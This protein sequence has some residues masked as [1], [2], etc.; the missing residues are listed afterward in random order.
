MVPVVF[1]QNYTAPDKTELLFFYG[2]GCPHCSQMKP[3][4]EELGKTY[5]DLDVKMYEV[6]S[7]NEN[8]KLMIDLA[9]AY[10]KEVSGVP[11]VFLG[12]NMIVGYNDA[13]G[14]TVEQEVKSCIQNGCD[15]P[16]DR[17]ERVN[18]QDATTIEGDS[19]PHEDPDRSAQIKTLTIPAVIGAAVVDAINP[20]AFAVLI[21]LLTT[22]LAAG[23]R[24]RVIYA[25]L[26]F[27]TSV[28]I[29]YFLMGIG[30][31]SALQAAGLTGTFYLIIS[32]LAIVVGL[33][34]LKDYL[35]YGKWFTM[36]VPR[37][38][39][40]KMKILLKSVTSIPGAFLVGFV[41]S[42]FLLPC[43]S[44][45]YIVILGLLAQVAS[46][47]YAIQML[48]LYNFIFVLPMILIT[49]AI[50]FG[51]TTTEKAEYWRTRK[52]K[53]LHLIAGIIILVLGIAMLLTRVFGII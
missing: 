34:N 22:I 6:Y 40:P 10:G 25:G 24:R 46:R 29:S 23:N 4:L 50:Y 47:S 41:V 5:S 2:A 27:S 9:G 49:L 16:H 38:W 7:N 28:Y 52:L 51:V 8:R 37:S 53:V 36:E 43:T 18:N 17:L 14:R 44:G 21:I 35:W 19:S 1:S 26:A 45:P 32:I 48:L 33:F 13:I 42:L 39:R 11:T 3:F 12:A 31:F 20:C 30:L 15:N